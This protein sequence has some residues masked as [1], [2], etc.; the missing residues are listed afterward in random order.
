M[1]WRVGR[2]ATIRFSCAF[3]GGKIPAMLRKSHLPHASENEICGHPET[4]AIR[5]SIG[6]EIR[7]AVTLVETAMH[8]YLSGNNRIA[9]ILRLEAEDSHT[10]VLMQI[11]RISEEEA[12]IVEATVTE[13]EDK[14][15]QLNRLL[16]NSGSVKLQ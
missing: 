5:F 7:A 1:H 12:D 9:Q 10:A 6:E 11:S 13:V 14:L 4:E 16:G 8:A 15:L 2:K 3:R